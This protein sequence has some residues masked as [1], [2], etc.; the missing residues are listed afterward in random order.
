MFGDL[1][2]RLN[3][4]SCSPLDEQI[5]DLLQKTWNLVSVSYIT[6]SLERRQPDV[7]ITGSSLCRAEVSADE[8]RSVVYANVGQ[9]SMT[10]PAVVESWFDLTVEEQ[11]RYLMEAFPSHLVYGV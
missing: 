8:V 1:Y 11:D 3:K 10:M 2:E 7:V 5:K 4:Y 6:E 9:M